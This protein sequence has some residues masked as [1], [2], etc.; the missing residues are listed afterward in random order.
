MR[1]IAGYLTKNRNEKDQKIT[2]S[3]HEKRTP[4]SREK[5]FVEIQNSFSHGFPIKI[6]QFEDFLA[7]GRLVNADVAHIG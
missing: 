2:Q 4:S 1:K 5:L 7:R 3:I 6:E